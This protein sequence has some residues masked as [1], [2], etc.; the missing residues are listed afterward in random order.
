ML[1]EPRIAGKV[2]GA[3]NNPLLSIRDLRIEYAT[4]GPPVRAVDGVSFDIAPGEV[5]GLAGESGSG[6]STVA[7]GILRLLQPPAV[8]TGGE[9]QFKGRDL[10]SL[11]D[12]Q[13]SQ[14]RWSEIS[15]VMQS[16]MNALNPVLRVGDQITDAIRAHE[17]NRS[18]KNC[19]KR[20][21]ELFKIVGIDPDRVD[22]YPHE[23]SGGM[24]QRAMIAMALALDPP[25]M[26]MDEPTT[27]LD[28]V[29]QKEI[30]Q[31]IEDLKAKLGFSILFITH[32]L[33]LLVEFS[34]RIAIMYAGKI[35]ELA[36]AKTLFGNP[37]HPYTQGLMT[38]FPTLTG[39]RKH[40]TGIPGSPPD[41]ACPP[42]GCRFH[43]RCPKFQPMHARVEPELVEVEPG[44]WVACH[45]HALVNGKEAAWRS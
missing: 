38:S 12:T 28:V 26:I 17:P 7:H 23:L 8:I 24:R 44:H 37:L 27:A 18:K 41:M 14:F 10:F 22:A 36:P 16:A 29:V 11:S 43:P 40:L 9:V 31:E 32:D 39:P 35:V 34:D 25:M 13:L 42:S 20:A 5:F 6:K 21:E 1:T 33:S 19:H 4:D 15:M 45:L 2:P 30:M 3:I